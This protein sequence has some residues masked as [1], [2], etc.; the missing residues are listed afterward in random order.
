[1]ALMIRLARIVSILAALA[2]MLS[3]PLLAMRWLHGGFGIYS[4]QSDSMRPAIAKGDAVVVVRSGV[5]PSVGQVVTY[6]DPAKAGLMVSHRLIAYGDGKVVT[7]GDANATPDQPVPHGSIVGTVRVRVPDAGMFL[8]GLRRPAGLIGMVY[9]PACLLAWM[10]LR[11]LAHLVSP[12][13][14]VLYR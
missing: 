12:P 9:L 14:Y 11:R 4:V 10:E 8:D 6:R 1:M 5:R 2:L 13:T 7:K 3:L